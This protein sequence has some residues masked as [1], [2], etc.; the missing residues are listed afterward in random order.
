MGGAVLLFWNLHKIFSSCGWK[1]KKRFR[2]FNLND[3]FLSSLV[4]GCKRL[5][6]LFKGDNLKKKVVETLYYRV[7]K[8]PGFLKNKEF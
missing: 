6:N 5:F 8:K 1:A 4:E 2:C 7:A 3:S